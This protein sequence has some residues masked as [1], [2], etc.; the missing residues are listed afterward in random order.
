MT[1]PRPTIPLKIS[2]VFLAVPCLRSQNTACCNKRVLQKNLTQQLGTWVLVLCRSG[3]V[4]APP[5]VS[6]GSPSVLRGGACVPAHTR[7]A[8]ETT[9]V[10]M[11]SGRPRPRTKG[12]LSLGGLHLDQPTPAAFPLV[13]QPK[14]EMDQ[15]QETQEG[16]R[17]MG[18]QGVGARQ[19]V[20]G[21]GLCE[22][23]FRLFHFYQKYRGERVPFISYLNVTF[24]ETKN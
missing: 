5:S 4:K 22:K 19:G 9:D 14:L 17:G 23:V 6:L 8:S 10:S 13:C 18:P 2:H 21:Q 1:G 20:Q 15:A 12:P 16:R 7:V 24:C 3:L 11:G